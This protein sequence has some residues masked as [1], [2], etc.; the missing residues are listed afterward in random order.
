MTAVGGTTLFNYQG[1]YAGEEVWNLLGLGSG[2]T[3]GGISTVFAI[4]DWQKPGGKSVAAA[5]GGSSTMRNVPDVAAVGDPQTGVSVY[6]STAGG[7]NIFGGTSAS[8]PIWA[9]FNSVMNGARSG[10][11][12]PP[13]GFINPLLYKLGESDAF[14]TRDVSDGS[15]G[16]AQIYGNPGYNAGYGYDDASGWGSINLGR[17]VYSALIEAHGSGAKPSAAHDVSVTPSTGSVVVTWTA[18]A[19]ATG[20]LLTVGPADGGTPV[21]NPLV[22]KVTTGTQATVGALASGTV[23]YIYVTALNAA[24]STATRATFFSTPSQ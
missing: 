16:N 24:R 13:F 22:N 5:N 11:G 19:G 12:L 17:Y 1:A 10:A 6:I 20:Y 2:A 3:G 14:G 21:P 9:G 4:P 23:Y 8:S 18:G 15:N 7:W